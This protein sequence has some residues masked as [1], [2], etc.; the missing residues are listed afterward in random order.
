MAKEIELRARFI[1]SI[2]PDH[3]KPKYLIEKRTN[4]GI[5]AGGWTSTNHTFVKNEKI[6]TAQK[7]LESYMKT[8]LNIQPVEEDLAYIRFKKIE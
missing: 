5:F 4:T 8:F 1:P 2:S 6:N 7:A 3:D